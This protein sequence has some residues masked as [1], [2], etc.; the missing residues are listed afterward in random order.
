MEGE[1]RA[2]GAEQRGEE[3]AGVSSKQ[4]LEGGPLEDGGEK[5]K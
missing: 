1:T 5:L 3:G 4:V 2:V